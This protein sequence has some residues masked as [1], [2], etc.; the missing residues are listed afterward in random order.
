LLVLHVE[1]SYLNTGMCKFESSQT[2]KAVRGLLIPRKL[3]E[4]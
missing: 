3:T 4:I 2:M 1:S